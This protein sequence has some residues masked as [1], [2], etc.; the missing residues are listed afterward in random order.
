MNA[1]VFL[2]GEFIVQLYWQIPKFELFHFCHPIFIKETNLLIYFKKALKVVHIS[3]IW[4]VYWIFIFHPIL[5]HLFFYWLWWELPI[6]CNSTERGYKCQMPKFEFLIFHPKIQLHFFCNESIHE[7]HYFFSGNGVNI[8]EISQTW[9]ICTIFYC[10][11]NFDAILISILIVTT[12]FLYQFW[13]LSWTWLQYNWYRRKSLS[14]CC[15]PVMLCQ[16]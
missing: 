14:S 7:I 3:H 10:L 5:M 16:E 2:H 12:D 11:S 4:K 8:F 6:E 1:F 13:F 9:K 15:G